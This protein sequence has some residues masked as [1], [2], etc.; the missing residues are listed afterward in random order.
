MDFPAIKRA[1]LSGFAWQ[2]A[3]KVVV[4]TASWAST[5][6]VAR[7]IAPS[8]YGLMAAAAVFAQL[9]MVLT[10]LGLAQ[11]LIQKKDTSRREEDGVF[12]LSLALGLLAYAFLYMSAPAIARFYEMP[13][14]VEIQRVLGLMIVFAS[15]KTVPLAIA[16]RRMDFRYRSLVEMGS[17]LAMTVTVITLAVNGFGVWSLV[18]GPIVAQLVMMLA[19][20]PLLGR[21]P[22][23]TLF[24]REV[25]AVL[26][27]G[28]KVTSTH[29]LYFVWSRADVM[30]IGKVLGEKMLGLYSMAFQLAVLPLDKV[31]AIF[32]QV[33]FPAMSRLQDELRESQQ[34]FLELHRYL[35]I[36]TY[37][38]LFGL[39]AI[40]PEL[41]EL[42]LT[43]TWLPI[44]PYLQGLCL[45]SA[46]RV[47]GMLMPP[48]LYARGKPGYMVRY[49]GMCVLLLPP[50]FLIG[51][52]FGLEG[53]VI[54][55]A[56]AY[57]ALCVLLARFCL[58]DL[59]LGWG[60]LLRSALPAL[61]AT[62]VML[63][64]VFSYRASLGDE[65][66]LFLRVL[67]TIAVGAAAYLAFLMLVYR[68]QL[69]DF[70][71]RLLLLR[72]GG[73]GT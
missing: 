9:L 56:L 16:M 39:I 6:F 19:Y 51:A 70:K 52:Q 15:L 28:V 14:L 47:S 33:I 44:V 69:L 42:L 37:P 2:G 3:T 66:G 4:Q 63:T 58:R 10:E 24:S 29:L 22:K 32:N 50:S 62:A 25:A 23:P 60:D 40:A 11:G 41:I 54:A 7:L 65:L 38:L 59:S 27:F 43:E 55:W 20:L 18:W 72:S 13:V 61:G 68:Q 53:V 73:A 17:S 21:I 49:S 71:Q 5:I 57:P 30:I 12:Y 36:V 34:L 1:V 31:G 45:V 48:V 8:D 26:A 67:S 35:L 46:L 64:A